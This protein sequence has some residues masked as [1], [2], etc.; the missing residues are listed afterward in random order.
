MQKRGLITVFLF[1]GATLTSVVHAKLDF[2]LP[3][4]PDASAVVEYGIWQKLYEL[5]KQFNRFPTHVSQEVNA[6]IIEQGKVLL[7]FYP[8]LI[9]QVNAAGSEDFPI[10]LEAPFNQKVDQLSTLLHFL[11]SHAIQSLG[12]LRQD[13]FWKERYDQHFTPAFQELLAKEMDRHQ[14]ELLEAAQDF[15]KNAQT[16]EDLESSKLAGKIA[17]R[18]N[19]IDRFVHILQEAQK[20]TKFHCSHR[21]EPEF[22][23]EIT[24]KVV[25]AL[26]EL[27]IAGLDFNFRAILFIGRV[28]NLNISSLV[29][30]YEQSR[31]MSEDRMKLLTRE[32]A[33]EWEQSSILAKTLRYLP[34]SI[35]LIYLALL[36]AENFAKADAAI[37]LSIVLIS[38]AF[39]NE[40]VIKKMAAKEGLS[41]TKQQ[42][43]SLRL[44][45]QEKIVKLLNEAVEKT[46]KKLAPKLDVTFTVNAASPLFFPPLAEL[47]S[48]YEQLMSKEE[49]LK[50][51]AII[52][53]SKLTESMF[54][55]YCRDVLNPQR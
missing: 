40:S 55:L 21:T 6:L 19:T 49:M 3:P 5:S 9:R 53:E 45:F 16:R 4:E 22:M 48:P 8:E 17:Q 36:S 7:A 37:L 13:P 27:Q 44:H 52:I 50:A 51:A 14:A 23:Y 24:E 29:E 32:L 54:F 26:L 39:I 2:P 20:E 31:L 41:Q 43:L 47:E 33:A 35:S 12:K 10:L 34:P 30:Q 1:W 18:K 42:A 28:I 25:H 46:F 38:Q 15:L 11:S